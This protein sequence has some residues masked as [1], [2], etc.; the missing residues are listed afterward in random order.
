MRTRAWKHLGIFNVSCTRPNGQRV[1][2]RCKD[3]REI[4]FLRYRARCAVLNG[5]SGFGW[6][7]LYEILREGGEPY[8]D[9]DIPNG[10]L[11]S[12]RDRSGIDGIMF[13]QG[14]RK[15]RTTCCPFNLLKGQEGLAR[16]RLKDGRERD[17]SILRRRLEE[18]APDAFMYAMGVL[19]FDY[20][21]V[22]GFRLH[23]GKAE[24]MVL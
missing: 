22:V 12:S 6:T 20:R 7:L 5:L 8:S 3:Q 13:K 18:V 14:L 16:L 2:F 24:V 19:Y 21:E 1:H 23:N 4:E 15:L 11:T 17:F 10:Y 9:A